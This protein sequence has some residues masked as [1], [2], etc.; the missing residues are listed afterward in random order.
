M[1]PIQ[2]LLVIVLILTTLFLSII[3]VQVTLTLVEFR[4]TLKQVRK[5]AKGFESIGVSAD[6]SLTEVSGF[7]SGFKSVMKLY[8]VMSQ[9]QTSN[10]STTQQ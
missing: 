2:I 8:E 9:Q 1:D 5:V 3:G 10:G 4:K 6:Q 7:V